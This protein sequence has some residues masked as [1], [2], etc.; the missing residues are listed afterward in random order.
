MTIRF[1]YV[2]AIVL[3]CVLAGGC[4]GKNQP[5]PGPVPETNTVKTSDEVFRQELET[6]FRD[7]RT[8]LQA[9][10]LQVVRQHLSSHS[11]R[12]LE[13]QAAST[14]TDLGKLLGKAA[15]FSPVLDEMQYVGMNRKPDTASLLYVG[16]DTVMPTDPPQ[17]VLQLVVFVREQGEWRFHTT[18]SQSA[19]GVVSSGP[20][21]AQETRFAPPDNV[22]SPPPK[23][24]EPDYVAMYNLTSYGYEARLQVNDTACDP[25]SGAS[26]SGLLMGGLRAG[27]NAVKLELKP[28]ADA[29]MQTVELTI[30]ARSNTDRTKTCEVLSYK[31][32]TPAL[33][34]ETVVKVDD[35]IVP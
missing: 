9:G 30:R 15:A 1:P 25:V 18:S 19:E 6:V 12:G 31:P 29:T 21:L 2:F 11:L 27:D 5:G 4:G 24:S 8:A 16:N 26:H 17:R 3:S 32:E 35:T 23:C 14:K 33:S 7:W 13:N 34:Y 28:V 20:E 10:N 22:P